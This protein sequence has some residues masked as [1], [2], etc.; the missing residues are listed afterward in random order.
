MKKIFLLIVVPA[1]LVAMGFAQT[2]TASDNTDQIN[3]KGCLGGSYGN[4]T[5]AEDNTGKIFKITSSADLK[6][7]VGQDVNF[8]GHKA[9]TAEN[10]I[11]VTEFNMISEQCATA[12]AAPA[13]TVSTTPETIST[14]PAAAAAP[15]ADAPD[16]AVS[17]PVSTPPAA[18][19]APAATVSTP[20][21]TASAPPAA[22]PVHRT[23]PAA[24]PRKSS[25]TPAAAAAPAEPVSTP[26]AD[27]AVPT[28]PVGPSSETASTP[29]APAE[30]AAKAS[31]SRSAGLLVSVVVVVLL[32][33]AAVPLYNR[34]KKR[35][36]AEQTRGQNLSFTKEAKT[37][38]GKTDTT[39]GRKAA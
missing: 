12:A 15:A 25:A 5:V 13:A 17:A 6:A 34:W 28:A 16:A 11:A 18:A 3:I 26:V 14:P 24:R 27:A 32:I 21:V 23:E 8:I 9:G 10:S 22:T 31:T 4:Y 7:Y 36:L 38:P 2:P 37:D 39:G 33:G 35:R 19:A 1:L 20:A 30:A 29:V